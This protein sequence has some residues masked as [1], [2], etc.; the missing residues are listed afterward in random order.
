MTDTAGE[1]DIAGV[2]DTAGGAGAAVGA[3]VAAESQTGLSAEVAVSWGR[4]WL[5]SPGAGGAK[6]SRISGGMDTQPPRTT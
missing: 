1:A 2:A 5:F 4:K 3:E 6:T